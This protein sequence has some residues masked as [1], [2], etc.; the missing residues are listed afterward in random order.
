MELVQPVYQEKVQ[1]S[2]DLAISYFEENF[3]SDF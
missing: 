2:C 1:M 3:T